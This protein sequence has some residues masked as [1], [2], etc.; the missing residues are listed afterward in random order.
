MGYE[1]PSEQTN[2]ANKPADKG[3]SKT[4]TSFDKTGQSSQKPTGMETKAKD[5]SCGTC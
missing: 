4:D 3:A 1:K 2:T 5:G